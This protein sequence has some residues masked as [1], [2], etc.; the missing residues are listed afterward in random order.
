MRF[1]LA[2]SSRVLIM[3]HGKKIFEGLPSQVAEDPVVVETYLGKGTQK[4][5]KTF[6]AE[7]EVRP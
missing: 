5:L 3:H 7:E 1:L 2:L 6:F 4:R